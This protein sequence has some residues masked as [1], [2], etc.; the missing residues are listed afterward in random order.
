MTYVSKKKNN[1]KC[2]NIK[3]SGGVDTFEIK[4]QNHLH[5]QPANTCLILT[6]NIL[7]LHSGS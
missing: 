7:M 1:Q 4:V 6:V 3:F 5:L 2:S